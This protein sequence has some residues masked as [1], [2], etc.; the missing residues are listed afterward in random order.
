MA[1]GNKITIVVNESR[2]S[3]QISWRCSGNS[4]SLNLSQEAGD[5]PN[6]TLPRTD[7]NAHYWAD[8]LNQV[9]PNL[10]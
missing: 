5:L 2:R 8:V 7:T 6:G 10:T 3:A 1:R 9:L 4:G